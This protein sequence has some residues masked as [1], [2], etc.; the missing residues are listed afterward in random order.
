MKEFKKRF[1]TYGHGYHLN[2]RIPPEEAY[3]FLTT[4]MQRACEARGA[5]I[6]EAMKE[7]SIQPMQLEWYLPLVKAWDKTYDKAFQDGY[8]RAMHDLDTILSKITHNTPNQ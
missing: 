8:G 1:T 6:A 2:D 7:Q 5:E 3:D 4:A